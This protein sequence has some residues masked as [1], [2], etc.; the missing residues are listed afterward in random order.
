MSR[1]NPVNGSLKFE[2][3]P[4]DRLWWRNMEGNPTEYT[5]AGVR[6]FSIELD[7]EVGK[8]LSEAGWTCVKFAPRNKREPE[9]EIIPRMKIN[10]NLD[11]AYPPGIYVA[12]SDG[13]RRTKVP[14]TWLND[15]AI[16]HRRIEW[17][18]IEVNP[19]NWKDGC[20]AYL[21]E[22]VIKLHEGGFASKYEDDY[23]TPDGVD[24]DIPF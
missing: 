6:Y 19:Y 24:E 7:D 23:T 20:S 16:D 1:E 3:V 22:M 14:G 21:A 4:G 11:S 18:D 15:Q 10:I 8:K 12:S 17:I 5:D 13:R 2:G 9:S